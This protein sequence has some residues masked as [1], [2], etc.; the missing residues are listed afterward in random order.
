MADTIIKSPL[1]KTFTDKFL[2]TFNLPEALKDLSNDYNQLTSSLGIGKDSI[3]FSLISA[4]IPGHTIKAVDQ[5]YGG[6]HLHIST[7]TKDA[8]EPVSIK[9]KI[10][11]SYANYYVLYEWMNLVWD[12]REGHYN[13]NKLA[14]GTSIDD[15]QTKMSVIALNE[16]N[17]PIMQWIFTH[18]FPT[19]LSSIDYNYQST[20]EIECTATFVFAQMITRNLALER[21]RNQQSLKQIHVHQ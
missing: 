12:E 14:K 17:E 1:N 16:Y 15:Y 13:A 21:L 6:G 10:D 7:H 11:S 3:D 2:F 4:S 9:F 19:S 18:A 5:Q 8:Y 20:E